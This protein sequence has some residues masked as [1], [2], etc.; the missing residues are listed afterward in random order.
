MSKSKKSN[1]FTGI[2]NQVIKLVVV[3]V[4]LVFGL[5]FLCG[6]DVNVSVNLNRTAP[7]EADKSFIGSAVKFAKKGYDGYQAYK[8]W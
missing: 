1:I 6:L 8:Q 4:L 2:V 3:G 5:I 7:F